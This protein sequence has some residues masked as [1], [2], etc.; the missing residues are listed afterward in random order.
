MNFSENISN[1]LTEV[2]VSELNYDEDKKEI[3]AYAI[4][5]VLFTFLGLVSIV[6]LGYLFDS[7][8]PTV[9]AAFFGGTLRR[10]S[11]GAHFD[12]PLK[13]LA[14]GSLV[15]SFLGVLANQLAIRGFNHRSYLLVAVIISL[16]LVFKFAPVDSEAKPINSGKLKFKL[17]VLSIGF[18]I[19]SFI[20]IGIANNSLFCISTT[21]GIAYQSI[22][23]IPIFNKGGR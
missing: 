2:I 5:N 13:C 12:T 16:F 19:V 4:E 9:I 3:I 7:L 11:G 8:I 20:L 22:T 17:R 15:Y 10:V 6:F 21:L 23:L 18:V 14:V 1:K